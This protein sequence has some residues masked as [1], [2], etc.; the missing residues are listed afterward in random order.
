MF[1]S[2]ATV[3][4]THPLK[5]RVEPGQGLQGWLSF[6]ECT[7]SHCHSRPWPWLAAP[8]DQLCGWFCPWDDPWSGCYP[9]QAWRAPWGLSSRT[10]VLRGWQ[11]AREHSGPA[12]WVVRGPECP[13]ESWEAE[14]CWGSTPRTE[15]QACWCWEGGRG[16]GWLWWYDW[17]R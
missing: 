4:Q 2:V 10:R 7:E 8:S 17:S 9:S 1:Y 6:C 13:V 14:R 5:V 16:E 12:S 3:T 11:T 15:L